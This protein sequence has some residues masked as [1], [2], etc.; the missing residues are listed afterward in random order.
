MY[1]RHHYTQP[2]CHCGGGGCV[3]LSLSLSLS[4]SLSFYMHVCL[5]LGN[6]I[7][8]SLSLPP[9]SPL[10]NVFCIPPS[11]LIHTSIP[12]SI[13]PSQLVCKCR[14][15]FGRLATTIKKYVQQGR[16][17]VVGDTTEIRT[18][19]ISSHQRIECRRL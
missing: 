4:P 14:F 1:S 3:D 2:G 11:P 7:S 19:I 6:C 12:H 5:C 15:Y 10:E 18:H 8:L 16:R 17:K 9:H 13:F